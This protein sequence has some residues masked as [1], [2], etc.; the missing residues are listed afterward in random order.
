M[1]IND[2]ISQEELNRTL[3]SL[4]KFYDT[5]ETADERAV[6]QASIFYVWQRGQNHGLGNI[7]AGLSDKLYELRNS[8]DK[9][10][11]TPRGR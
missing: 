5:A 4:M 6:L 3:R 9:G 7:P 2:K 8:S 11:S 1:G 10:F